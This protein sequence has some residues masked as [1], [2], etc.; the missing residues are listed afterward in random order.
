MTEV[1]GVFVRFRAPLHSSNSAASR[2]TVVTQA[3]IKSAP[4]FLRYP[5]F[6][7]KLHYRVKFTSHPAITIIYACE[8]QGCTLPDFFLL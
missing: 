4:A 8:L 5:A 3:V 7:A 2:R 1:V 6:S